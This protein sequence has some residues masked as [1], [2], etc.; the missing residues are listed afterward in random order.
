MRPLKEKNANPAFPS[1][2]KCSD[3]ILFDYSDKSCSKGWKNKND[4]EKTL[5]HDHRKQK[6]QPGKKMFWK[7]LESIFHSPL[8]GDRWSSQKAKGGTF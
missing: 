7:F 8:F 3:N 5:F 2:P 6:Q 1:F 4:E